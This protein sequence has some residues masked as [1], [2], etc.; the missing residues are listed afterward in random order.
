M[1][2]LLELIE[3]KGPGGLTLASCALAHQGLDIAEMHTD[4]KAG[5]KL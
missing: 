4:R 5:V 1:E 3:K 2:K